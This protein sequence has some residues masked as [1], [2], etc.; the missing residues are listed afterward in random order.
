MKLPD[1]AAARTWVQ[2]A[3]D[4]PLVARRSIE[5][6]EAFLRADRER[7]TTRMAIAGVVILLIFGLV[8]TGAI[9]VKRRRPILLDD[10]SLGRKDTHLFL[11]GLAL[12]AV[13]SSVNNLRSVLF[14]YDT[15]QAWSS[16][17]TRTAL[18]FVVAIPLV[19]V[20]F[21]LWLALS[22]MRRR[23]GI[24]MVAGE[25]SRSARNEIL[26]AGLGL[27][28]IFFIISQLDS[29]V[30][31]GGMPRTPTTALNELFPLLGGVLDMPTSTLMGI[32]M[33]G[34]P[35]LV[36]AALTQRWSLRALMAAVFVA[37]L[38]VL[39]WS[40]SSGNADINPV[41]VALAIA[42]LASLALALVFW[43][44][45]AAWSWIVA[46]L[47]YQGLAGLRNAAYAAV[48]QERAAG[49][50]TLIFALALLTLIARRT[51]RAH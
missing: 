22:A 24:P 38:L 37:L 3:G 45:L 33:V 39:A 13:L 47:A 36:V 7:Q 9:F 51:A 23:A 34:I 29:Y 35:F 2:V 44:G 28:S 40:T 20:V 6:P 46:A 1:G 18:G 15:A 5:L 48:W 12:L 50:L 17:L 26:V 8:V 32:A 41:R 21:G 25:P 14:D 16:F 27:G 30:P 42:G 11:G 19:L 43:G 4:E 49:A 10:G 31:G